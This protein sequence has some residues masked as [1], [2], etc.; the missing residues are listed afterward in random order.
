VLKVSFCDG[1]L[2]VV[3][4]PCVSACVRQ[5]FL[6]TTSPLKP[7]IGFWPNFKGII[8]WWSS[9]KVVQIGQVGCI[10]GSPV[11]KKVFR[12]Q[13][14]KSSWHTYKNQNF[15]ILYIALSRGP[16]PH[17]FQ[18]R[19]WGKNWSRSGGHNFK[20]NY[21]RKSSNDLLNRWWEFDQTSQEWSLEGPLPKS[22]IWIWLVA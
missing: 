6:L 22:F 11:K 13:F 17:L 16:L 3:H 9:T 8:P 7:L 5:Q 21:K 14:K 1:Q 10:N 2:S 18:F 19:P 20:L 4:R 15:H 12:M